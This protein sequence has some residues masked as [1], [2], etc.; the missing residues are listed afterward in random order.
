VVGGERRDHG[1]VQQSADTDSM[2]P[3]PSPAAIT[4]VVA[5]TRTPCHSGEGQG[6]NL[7][8]SGYEPDELPGCA[9]SRY[10]KSS[11]PGLPIIPLKGMKL[12]PHIL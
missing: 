3:M 6:L 1:Q 11:H 8:P 10:S 12:T 9:I 5:P 2:V 4:S 7:W